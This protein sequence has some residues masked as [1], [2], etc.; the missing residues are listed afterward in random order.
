VV[1]V[2]GWRNGRNDLAKGNIT[3]AWG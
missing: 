3:A 1:V 2:V